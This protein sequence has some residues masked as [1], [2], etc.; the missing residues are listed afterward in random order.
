MKKNSASGWRVRSIAGHDFTGVRGLILGLAGHSTLR[1]PEFPYGFVAKLLSH[2]GQKI[3]L[4]A[5]DSSLG[6]ALQIPQ[7]LT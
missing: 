6:S 2:M 4:V 7:F 5:S 3:A 1:C